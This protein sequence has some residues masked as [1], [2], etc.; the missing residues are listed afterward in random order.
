MRGIY[1]YDDL[2]D[3]NDLSVRRIIWVC[4]SALIGGVLFEKRNGV[5]FRERF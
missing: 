2:M 3:I 5:A 4:K 1:G